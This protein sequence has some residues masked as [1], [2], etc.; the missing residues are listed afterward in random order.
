MRNLLWEISIKGLWDLLKSYQLI[1]NVVMRIQQCWE[2][3][4]EAILIVGRNVTWT[5]WQ[6]VSHIMFSLLQL[7]IQ[8]NES[9]KT[10]QNEL[11]QKV[12]VRRVI[13]E[14]AVFFNQTKTNYASRQFK[15]S[16][17]GRPALL[18]KTCLCSVNYHH[19]AWLISAG[20][21]SV[22]SSPERLHEE[23]ANRMT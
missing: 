20:V 16:S 6:A 7:L 8:W 23:E 5:K 11:L 19:H 22:N 21:H 15:S 3:I 2:N 18:I 4:D 1:P 17:P 9:L 12:P 14:F 13:Q 10:S